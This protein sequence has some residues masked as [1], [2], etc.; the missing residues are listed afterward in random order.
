MLRVAVVDDEASARSEL[1]ALITRFSSENGM[2]VAV[3][4]YADG[5]EFLATGAAEDIVLLDIDMAEVSGMDVAR[6]LRKAGIASEI[7]FVTNMAQYAIKGYEVRALDFVVKPV[8][9]A[10]FAIKFRRA[11]DIAARKNNSRIPVETRKG[12]RYVDTSEIIYIEVKGHKLIF[13]GRRGTFEA[14]GTMKA[15]ST[16]FEPFG[17]ALCN[18]CYLVNLACVVNVAQDTVTVDGGDELKMS[19]GRKRGFM[20]ALT[21]SNGV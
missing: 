1:V 7:I 10:S 9:Y 3:A 14:W 15:V 16:V 17:F 19:R 21:H 11:V 4:E 12:L 13:H 18:A 5:T 6:L 8:R 20:D 2:Q